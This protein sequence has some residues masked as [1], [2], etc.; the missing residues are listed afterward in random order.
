V[1]AGGAELQ[2]MELCEGRS[3]GW[4]MRRWRAQN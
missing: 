3:G 2:L 4:P 1:S